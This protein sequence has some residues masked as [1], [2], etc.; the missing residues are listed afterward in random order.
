[1]LVHEDQL[2]TAR[3]LEETLEAPVLPLEP[4][5][6]AEAAGLALL[7][8]RVLVDAYTRLREMEEERRRREEQRRRTLT[9]E[10]LRSLLEEYRSRRA[11]RLMGAKNGGLEQGLVD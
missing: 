10:K 4:Y 5:L 1:V 2:E 8:P 7:D 9:R 6:E 3:Q 11:R